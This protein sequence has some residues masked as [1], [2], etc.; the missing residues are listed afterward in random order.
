LEKIKVMIVDDD[1]ITTG[2]LQRMMDWRRH[3]FDIVAVANNGKVGLIKHEETR[4]HIV[5]T[6]VVMPF[7]DGLEM[8]KQIR[9]K[10]SNVSFVI[11]SAYGEFEYARKAIE[12]G[13]DGYVLKATL[14]ERNLLYALLP[15]REK[16]LA[17]ISKAHLSIYTLVSSCIE[18][19]HNDLQPML[20]N[21]DD[22]FNDIDTEAEVAELSTIT[23]QTSE[24]IEKTYRIHGKQDFFKQKSFASKSELHQWLRQQI[25]LI[26]RWLEEEQENIISHSTS[27]A[28]LYIETNY[29]DKNL[30]VRDIA[31]AAS[32]S[33]SWLS[34]RFKKET[35]CSLKEYIIKIRI[36]R[37]KK[38][39][40]Q[41]NCRVYEV[42]DLVGFSS[43][44]YFSKVFYN[45]TKLLPHQ[46]RGSDE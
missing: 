45:N 8:I 2:D 42:A 32:T 34:T 15:V 9:E 43:G 13:A 44:Q 27:K 26:R 33:V 35:G 14:N 46:Y 23:R 4:P 7:M 12:L 21:L 36:D 1:K 25:T 31:D 5:L 29:Q 37:A 6:D 19:L 28:M 16:I 41:G 18:R 3:G 10:D 20:N 17:R 11:L 39:L 38:L 22:A 40:R 30:N 24:L